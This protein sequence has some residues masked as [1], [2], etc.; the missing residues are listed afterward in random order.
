MTTGYESKEAF[1]KYIFNCSHMGVHLF[2]DYTKSLDFLPYIIIYRG[3]FQTLRHSMY[4]LPMLKN[5]NKHYMLPITEAANLKGDRAMEKRENIIM[6][7]IELLK[8]NMF[9]DAKMKVLNEFKLLKV[10]V[11]HKFP[12]LFEHISFVSP[13]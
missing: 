7:T 13:F 4:V 8:Y 9:K 12:T 1:K 6:E 11:F 2:R 10:F 3:F 5:M